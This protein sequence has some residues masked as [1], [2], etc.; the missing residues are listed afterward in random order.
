M[1][2]IRAPR[3]GDVKFTE[4]YERH[5]DKFT[6]G[7]VYASGGRTFRAKHSLRVDDIPPSE[8]RST[9]M[10][11]IR[12]VY[13]DICQQVCDF[14]AAVLPIDNGPFERVALAE[15]TTRI[16]VAQRAFSHDIRSGLMRDDME[17]AVMRL[18]KL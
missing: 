8:D 11:L 10:G 15:A 4:V 14:H 9:H 3:P 13:A 16:V 2:I 7:G 18:C 5:D 12:K 1:T 17:A 6:V